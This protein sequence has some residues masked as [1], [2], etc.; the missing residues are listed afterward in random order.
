M[1]LLM[2]WGR[3][4]SQGLEAR[5]AK[6]VQ[7]KGG[8]VWKRAIVPSRQ[9]QVAALPGSTVSGGQTE[10]YPSGSRRERGARR[11]QGGDKAV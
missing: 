1:S 5:K 4:S 8:K 2:S 6:A 9:E 3:V 11:P 7:E 10:R